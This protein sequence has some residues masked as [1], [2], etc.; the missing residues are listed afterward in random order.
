MDAAGR[1]VLRC[2]LKWCGDLHLPPKNRLDPLAFPKALPGIQLVQVTDSLDEFI[3]RLVGTREVE[4]RGF[5]P[6]GRPVAEGFFG[7]TAEDVLENYRNA[8]KA[9]GP[10]CDVDTFRKVNDVDVID[11]SLFLP[12][13]EDGEIRYILVYSYQKSPE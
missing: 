2:W 8:V 11:I 5:D 10:M 3:Y 4:V 12:M 9:E 7:A 6:T 13:T 1:D